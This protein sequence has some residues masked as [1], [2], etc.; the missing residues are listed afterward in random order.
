MQEHGGKFTVCFQFACG[1]H[2]REM[3]FRWSKFDFAVSSFVIARKR[4]ILPFGR[5]SFFFRFRK[6]KEPKRKGI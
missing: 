3:R 4:A 5:S 6:K 1:E 2:Y